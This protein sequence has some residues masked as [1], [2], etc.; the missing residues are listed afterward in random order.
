MTCGRARNLPD[1]NIVIDKQTIKRLRTY[2]YLGLVL[3]V[4]R[5]FDNHID[6][7]KKIIRPFIPL[8]WRKGKC[9]PSDKRK[10]L[11]F[12]YVQSHLIYMLPIYSFGNK[13]KLDELQALQNGCIKAVFP[14]HR[15]TVATYLYSSS[16]YFLSNSLQSLSE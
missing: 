7:V 9:I 13:T 16:V 6:E 15:R 2:K 4:N 1:L 3:D 10:Q 5:T 11:Y 8:I 12:S 14:L